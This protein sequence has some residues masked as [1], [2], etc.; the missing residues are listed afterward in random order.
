MKKIYP[1]LGGWLIPALLLSP[2]LHAAAQ[3]D[4]SPVLTQLRATAKEVHASDLSRLRFNQI[5][6]IIHAPVLLPELYSEQR[7]ETMHNFL[8]NWKN[9]SYPSREL[10][11]AAEALLAIETGKF[12]AYWLPCDCLYYLE[13]YAREL[14][15]VSQQDPK[16]RYYLKLDYP[17]S[18]D[19]TRQAQRI[20]LFIRS[21]AR[22]LLSRPGLKN[23]ELYICRTLAG[24]IP[25]PKITL[26]SDPTAAPRISKLEND[27]NVYNDAVFTT[28]RNGFRGTAG[29]SLGWWFP[30]G[31]LQ[32]LG[33]HPAVGLLL[34]WRDEWNEYDLN[35][36]IRFGYPTPQTYTILRRD[37]VYATNYYDGGYIGFEYTRYLLH[38]KYVDLGLTSGI[39]Y[40]Y[41]DV[42]DG[43]S[44]H[45]HNP[46]LPLN[47]GSFDFNNGIRIKYFFK[48][49]AYIGLTAKYHLI[50]YDN[51]GGT[52]LNGNACTLDLTFGSH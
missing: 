23:D 3:E 35:W 14:Q 19:A 5:T 22:E 50:H 16:F 17:Y 10:I 20:L 52:N 47:V 27:L 30:T 15:L 38:R 24:D 28:R 6:F 34:G 41:F 40:D 4:S 31:H 46:G 9:A 11:F 51:S 13:D 43:F 1:S 36:N 8:V 21:W 7:Y 18:Y 2:F 37:T 25:H 39:A 33:S 45:A 48:K 44:T 42:A 29:I 32:A 12:S 26:R 49:K